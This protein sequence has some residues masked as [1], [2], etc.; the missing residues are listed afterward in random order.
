MQE[1]YSIESLIKH[2]RGMLLIDRLVEY[3]DN[4]IIV[5]VT[6]R[7]NSTFYK[8]G[9][10]PAWIGLEYAAQ[11]VGAYAGIYEK[12]LGHPTKVGFLLGCRKYHTTVSQFPLGMTI[13]IHVIEEFRDENMGVYQCTLY[14]EN[15]NVVATTSLSAYVPERLEDIFSVSNEKI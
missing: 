1:I 4:S 9:A 8:N 13:R 10:V 14:D 5:E 2:R 7:E 3:D 15:N 12:K 11:G 6:I